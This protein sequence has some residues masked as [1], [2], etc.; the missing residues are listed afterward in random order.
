M[1]SIKNID[2]EIFLEKPVITIN[3]AIQKLI[4]YIIDESDI[5]VPIIVI[6]S[7]VTFTI[8]QIRA[9]INQE[10]PTEN[11]IMYIYLTCIPIVIVFCYI[12]YIS[13][14]NKSKYMFYLF[15][16]FGLI[17]FFI[18]YGLVILCEFKFNLS[19]QNLFSYIFVGAIFLF[20]L[21]I[22]YSI[23]ENQMR[24]TDTWGSF[25]IEFIFYIP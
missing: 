21:T 22:F 17:V 23:F 11:L 25:W 13:F 12:L 14:D 10:K 15:C 24:T 16:V 5:I 7:L 19:L 2:R 1:L 4:Y 3:V 8:Y 6:G 9:A 20:S 18:I